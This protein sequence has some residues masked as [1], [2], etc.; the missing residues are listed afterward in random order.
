[1]TYTERGVAYGELGNYEQALHDHT[2]AVELAPHLAIAYTNR[3][4]A[5]RALGRHE[6]AL[7]DHTSCDRLGSVVC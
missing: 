7:Q 4:V 1:M 5:Y 2:R 3:G 6:Q